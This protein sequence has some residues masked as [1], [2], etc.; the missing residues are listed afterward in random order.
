[1][2]DEEHI[3]AAFGFLV[4][5][6]SKSSLHVVVVSEVSDGFLLEDIKHRDIYK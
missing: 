6:I 2:S 4:L 1:M 3:K 5:A